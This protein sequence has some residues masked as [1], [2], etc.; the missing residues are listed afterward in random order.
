MSVS[1][2]VVGISL[3]LT[4]LVVWALFNCDASNYD[5]DLTVTKHCSEFSTF[6]PRK[7]HT[8]VPRPAIKAATQLIKH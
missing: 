6:S 8:Q 1:D 4:R 5:S 2:A 7:V 3:F